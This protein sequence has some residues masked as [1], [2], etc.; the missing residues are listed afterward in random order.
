M[1]I[2]LFN[3]A[4]LSKDA[5]KLSHALIDVLDVYSDLAG[6][7]SKEDIDYI[8]S[9]DSKKALGETIVIAITKDI[10]V[11]V[12]HGEK[13]GD[14]LVFDMEDVYPYGMYQTKP[15]SS[16]A[17]KNIYPS[18]IINKIRTYIKEMQANTENDYTVAEIVE[19]LANDLEI[20][21]TKL[22]EDLDIDKIN[23][24]VYPELQKLFLHSE[25]Y[26]DIKKYDSDGRHMSYE[27]VRTTVFEIL[28]TISEG[29]I[30]KIVYQYDM[31]GYSDMQVGADPMRLDESQTF[32]HTNCENT[33]FVS[34]PLI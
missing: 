23:M 1:A 2:Q 30:D 8:L 16:F 17:N 32:T 5:S 7:M 22:M 29:K 12:I 15:L 10:K 31:P 19:R 13:D 33:Y 6:R 14:T 11:K 20:I 9:D 18:R 34:Q 27:D 3:K 28:K 26:H 4:D 21:H 24:S 25:F